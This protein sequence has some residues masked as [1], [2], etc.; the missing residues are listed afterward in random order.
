VT[1]VL[2]D[3]SLV[4]APADALRLGPDDTAAISILTLGELRAGVRLARDARARAARQA[5]LVAIRSA[6][7]PIPIDEPIAEHYGDLLAIA[8][9]KKRSSKAT[10][11][12]ITA[13]ALAT[14]RTLLTLDKAQVS[15]A[16]LAGVP[17][18]A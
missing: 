6:F 1:H 4:V 15:L 3:T 14:G 13:T 8:R 10:D 12:L 11:L 9:S 2:L 7:E 5:R 16:R 17:V 18:S